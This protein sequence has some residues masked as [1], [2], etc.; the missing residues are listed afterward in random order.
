[1]KIK[2]Q[3]VHF[4]ADKKLQD[5]IQK[6]ADKLYKIYHRIEDCNVILRLDKND[7]NKNKF[8]EINVKMLGNNFFVKD[9]ADTFEIASHMAFEEIRKQLQKHKEKVLE[10]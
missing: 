3:S 10:R 9:Q 8:V 2:I 7:Q 5:L 1:M 4:D 6:E